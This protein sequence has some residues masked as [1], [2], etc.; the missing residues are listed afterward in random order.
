[1]PDYLDLLLANY[2]TPHVYNTRGIRFRYPNIVCEAV[3][4]VLSYSLIT[5]L[6][7]LPPNLLEIGFKTSVSN[8]KMP[9][10]E[11]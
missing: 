6:E 10:S 3:T 7:K 8:S 9:F 5:I 1:M 2:I 4:R 11:K